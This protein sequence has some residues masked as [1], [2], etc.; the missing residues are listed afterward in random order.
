MVLQSVLLKYWYILNILI[1]NVYCNP[2]IWILRH[3]DKHIQQKNC[4][5]V[6]GYNRSLYWGD[7]LSSN[8]IIGKTIQMYASNFKHT[9]QCISNVKIESDIGCQKSQRM[10]ITANL[11]YGILH[12]KN[13][14]IKEINYKY[15]IKG[16]YKNMFSYIKD[17]ITEDNVIVI[18]QHDEIVEAL[19]YVFEQS[20]IH[21]WPKYLK[22]FYDIIFILRFNNTINKYQL[23][24]DCLDS[25]C[26]NIISNWLYLA[27]P[28]KDQENSID[29][30]NTNI[31][32]I[33]YFLFVFFLCIIN[34]F[35]CCIKTKRFHRSRNKYYYG[36]ILNDG[37]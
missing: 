26:K 7:Y 37:Y 4:C 36:S 17:N 30:N 10:L 3:C 35:Y 6:E 18:W 22:D 19:R 23:F 29:R 2:T 8:I 33:L 14:D 1:V 27:I 11:I 25:P 15:C 16:D 24:Y 28:W 21:K 5:S 12:N 20:Y 13:H 32:I 31:F 34:I 9:K